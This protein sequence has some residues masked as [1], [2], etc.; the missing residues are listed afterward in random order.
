MRA[1]P[2]LFVAGVACLAAAGRASA[3]QIPSSSDC[4]ARVQSIGENNL[5]FRQVGR[6]GSPLD[7]L[8]R[9]F[10]SQIADMLAFAPQSRETGFRTAKAAPPASAAA[11]C[12]A[13]AAPSQLLRRTFLGPCEQST[14]FAWHALTSLRAAAAGATRGR[15]HSAL[16]A[17]PAPPPSAQANGLLSNGGQLAYCLCNPD[18]L[19]TTLSTIAANPLARSAGVT[20]PSVQ[21]M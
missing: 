9:A 15:A 7:L 21:A 12:A 10:R 20:G 8:G 3:Q 16:G 1:A 17:P 4:A 2:L 18:V 11:R 14:V 19:S 5:L 13:G 6:G